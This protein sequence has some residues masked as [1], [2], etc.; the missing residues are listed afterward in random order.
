MAFGVESPKK[1]QPSCG[2]VQGLSPLTGGSLLKDRLATFHE[3]ADVWT[4]W[5]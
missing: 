4:G 5:F 2:V 3:Q 1:H